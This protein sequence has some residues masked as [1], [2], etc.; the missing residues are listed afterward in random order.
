MSINIPRAQRGVS[1]IESLVALLVLALGI[2]GLAGVQTRILVDTRTANHRA[3]AMGLIQDISNRMLL[4]RAETLSGS[5][6]T[7]WNA[8]VAVHNCLAAN[9]TAAPCT[10]AQMRQSDLNQWLANVR[11]TLPGG[12]ARIFTST[13][14]PRQIGIAIAWSANESNTAPLDGNSPL[15]ISATNHG[16][17][18]KP[19]SLCHLVYVQP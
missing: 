15:M 2:L 18:C 7:E 17:D 8:T 9:T 12:D 11:S 19:N 3:V 10:S 6:N 13:T 1:M 14:D 16:T 4:N 5:Y